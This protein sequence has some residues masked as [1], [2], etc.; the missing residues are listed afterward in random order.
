[1][2]REK[3]LATLM[4]QARDAYERGLPV[5]AAKLKIS[6]WSPVE[7]GDVALFT[8]SIS[9][10]ESLGWRLEHWAMAADSGGAACG[11]PIF[12]RST[13]VIQDRV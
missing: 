13:A 6:A 1:M 11:Y 2:S 10:V 8:E 12:R 3:D 9:A 5:F 4:S 7:H